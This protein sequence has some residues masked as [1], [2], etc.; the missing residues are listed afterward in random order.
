[1]AAL[2]VPVFTLTL[3]EQTDGFSL[4]ITGTDLPLELLHM[5]PETGNF[6]VDA[7]HHAAKCDAE[8]RPAGSRSAGGH[9]HV[10]L[11]DHTKVPASVVSVH[12][13]REL[14][15]SFGF[16]SGSCW[17]LISVLRFL[18]FPDRKPSCTR[19]FHF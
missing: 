5:I 3:L 6:T 10:V 9:W 1:M 14:F 12:A 15:F 13:V 16:V 2:D 11:A 17:K 19:W 8:S 18:K 7:V 4:E